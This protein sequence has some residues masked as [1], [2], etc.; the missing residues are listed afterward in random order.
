MNCCLKQTHV[1]TA[2]IAGEPLHAAIVDDFPALGWLKAD[3]VVFVWRLVSGVVWVISTRILH[4]G[5]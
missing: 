2:T 3:M 5:G 1:H 4:S